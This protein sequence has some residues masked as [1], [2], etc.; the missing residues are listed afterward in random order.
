[1]GD[2]ESETMEIPFQSMKAVERTSAKLRIW[3]ASCRGCIAERPS[4]AAV[5]MCACERVGVGMR[6]RIMRDR[7]NRYGVPESQETFREMCPWSSRQESGGGGVVD[8]SWSY[9]GE[10]NARCPSIRRR[11]RLPAYVN[12]L[13]STPHRRPHLLHHRRSWTRDQLRERFLHCN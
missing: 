4:M 7:K 1:M 2:G 11:L 5:V 6:S 3:P 8:W 9:V 13:R 12:H 10:L